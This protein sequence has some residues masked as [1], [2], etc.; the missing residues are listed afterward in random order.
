M[1]RFLPTTLL[2]IVTFNF[3]AAMPPKPTSSASSSV[4]V[5]LPPD[6]A[7]RQ[8]LLAN[9]PTYAGEAALASSAQV[10]A[11]E[12]AAFTNVEAEKIEPN[13]YIHIGSGRS[14]KITDGLLILFTALLAVFTFLLWVST[15]SLWKETQR[16]GKTAEIAANAA[17]KSALAAEKSADASFISV[18]ASIAAQ[19]PRWL[20]QD[21]YIYARL[22]YPENTTTRSIAVE[23]TNH[24]STSAE[25]T[26]TVLRYRVADALAERPDYEGETDGM[27]QVDMAKH[28]SEFGKITKSGETYTIY[29][30]LNLDAHQLAAIESGTFQLWAYGYVQYR[31][32]L[33]RSW[34]KSFIGQLYGPKAVLSPRDNLG[35][36]TRS[37]LVQPLPETNAETYTYTRRVK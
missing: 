18:E 24:G 26:R 28:G 11:P 14:I 19:Q 12:L 27:G 37:D 3:A 4:T 35:P 5:T 23:L 13:E 15:R 29:R 32:F 31:D 25:I 8:T 2:L 10:A 6:L 1:K 36:G 30:A 22:D 9:S 21:M 17:E 16:G 34:E 33:D 7:V 20:V